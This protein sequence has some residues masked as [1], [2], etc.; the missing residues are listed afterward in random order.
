MEHNREG[1]GK[2]WYARNENVEMDGWSEEED[3]IKNEYMRGSADV[4]SVQKIVRGRRLKWSGNVWRR[5]EDYV[6]NRMLAYKPGASR[7]G[8]PKTR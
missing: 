3:R 4:R 5:N 8:R 7:R 2:I 1:A 6:G